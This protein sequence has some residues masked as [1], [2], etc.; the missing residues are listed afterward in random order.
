MPPAGGDGMVPNSSRTD[1]PNTQTHR[2]SV[3]HAADMSACGSSSLPEGA[4]DTSTV[5]SDSQ[6]SVHIGDDAAPLAV[7]PTQVT[8]PVCTEVCIE[9]LAF[10]CNCG[11]T[12]DN[13]LLSDGC[14]VW[15]VQCRYHMLK[16]SVKDVRI[17]SLRSKPCF[18]QW[19][20]TYA[21][22]CMC[23]FCNKRLPRSKCA[24]RAIQNLFACS[25]HS[26]GAAGRALV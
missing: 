25:K 18:E 14:R 11:R 20:N 19:F 12:L 24:S 4:A 22:N 23:M 8:C 26:Q 16:A 13:R 2:S 17:A 15:C 21:T 7:L 1:T 9:P 3:L 6:G 10:D 5:I